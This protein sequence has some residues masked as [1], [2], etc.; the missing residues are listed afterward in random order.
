MQSKHQPV[1][2]KKSGLVSELIA[3]IRENLILTRKLSSA[4]YHMNKAYSKVHAAKCHGTDAAKLTE[5]L[6][7]VQRRIHCS[8]GYKCNGV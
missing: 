5:H 4:H 7:K 2:Q 1:Q 3:A 6:V 8:K